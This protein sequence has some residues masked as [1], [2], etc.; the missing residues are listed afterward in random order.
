M[1][2]RNITVSL[3][4]DL[5]RR[6]KIM[7]VQRDTSV[8][9]LLTDALTELVLREDAYEEAHLRHLELLAD[10]P[11]LGTAGDLRVS[12]EALHERTI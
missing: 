11:D 2:R 8:S 3:P 1:Q 12:R 5:L 6:I 9:A 4:S 7:A 10:P